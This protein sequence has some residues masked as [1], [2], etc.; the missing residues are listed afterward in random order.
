MQWM[1]INPSALIRWYQSIVDHCMTH[2]TPIHVEQLH[3]RLDLKLC[4]ELIDHSSDIL[5]MPRLMQTANLWPSRAN[6]M[7]SEVSQ[8]M[9]WVVRSTSKA[10]RMRSCG[11]DLRRSL[12]CCGCRCCPLDSAYCRFRLAV[13]CACSSWCSCEYYHYQV[14]PWMRPISRDD[15]DVH[16]TPLLAL[17]IWEHSTKQFIRLHLNYSTTTVSLTSLQPWP[18]QVS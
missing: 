5:A 11:R 16:H 14:M 2:S 15:Y 8:S 7:H 4:R 10:C 18:K 1:T 12:R 3:P 17:P 13:A 9:R 6:G